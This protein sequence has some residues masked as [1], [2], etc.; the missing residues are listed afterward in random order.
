MYNRYTPQPDGTYKRKSVQIQNRIIQSPIPQETCP[1][2]QDSV[3]P[4]PPSEIP[5]PRIHPNHN[6]PS[7]QPEI[8]AGAFL[9]DLLPHNLDT[10]DLLIIILLLLIAADGH[11]DHG[12]A[13]LTLALYL[14]L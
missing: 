9:K 2:I 7:R 13:L 10:G 6:K 4:P 3:L 12:S 14:F 11:D 1:P 8:N 5:K